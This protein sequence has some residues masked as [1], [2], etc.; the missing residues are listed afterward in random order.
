MSRLPTTSCA[1][2]PD[3]A[4]AGSFVDSS[5]LLATCGFQKRNNKH[6][7]GMLWRDEHVKKE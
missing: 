6:T 4:S 1:G 5:M 3:A 2:L 7:R